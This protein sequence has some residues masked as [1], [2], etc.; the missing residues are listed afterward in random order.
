MSAKEKIKLGLD[1]ARMLTL[2]VQ[3]L[4]GFQCRAAFQ[5]R[6]DQL[7]EGARLAE[8]VSLLLLLVSLCLLIAPGLQHIVVERLQSTAR[9]ERI[10]NVCQTI[11]LA[12]LATALGLA[13]AIAA[14]L[15]FGAG[16]V[17]AGALVGA[18]AFAFWFAAPLVAL[19]HM[20][21]KERAMAE[22]RT[23]KETPVDEQLDHLLTEA[24][25]IL[26]GAQ[27][28]LGFQLTVALTETFARIPPAMRATHLAALLLV[29][30]CVVLLMTPA[31]FHRIVYRG[32][33]SG[34][35]VALASI[36]VTGAMAPLGIALALEAALV[37]SRALSSTPVA[38]CV[39]LGVFCGLALAWLVW[40]LVARQ[41]KS[42][43]L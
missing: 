36:L 27:A 28:L 25:T 14:G 10:L 4:I 3:V 38:V 23:S 22:A 7:S 5:Q 8:T 39:G 9:I 17:A 42:R 31:A 21:Q 32:E 2:G 40:P 37:S 12:P 30:L 6:F 33:E 29:T 43:R 18:C 35:L 34:R 24:R 1:E 13:V 41:R 20:G 16:G 26:P 11:A 15:D 19:S